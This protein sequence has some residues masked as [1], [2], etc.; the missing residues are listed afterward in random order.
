MFTRTADDV[1]RKL[2]LGKVDGMEIEV[3]LARAAICC[4]I[5]ARSKTVVSFESGCSCL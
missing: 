2:W 1:G 4:E 3:P 5:W